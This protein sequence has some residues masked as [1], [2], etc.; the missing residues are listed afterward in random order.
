MSESTKAITPATRAM[1]KSDYNTIYRLLESGTTREAVCSAY[2]LNPHTLWLRLRK[3]RPDLAEKLKAL[4]STKRVDLNDAAA[5]ETVVKHRGRQTKDNLTEIVAHD[6]DVLAQMV[7][8]QRAAKER[9]PLKE[10][11]PVGLP[12][13]R[14]LLALAK[15]AAMIPGMGMEQGGGGTT[16]NVNTAVNHASVMRLGSEEMFAG[17]DDLTGAIIDVEVKDELQ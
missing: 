15:T 5:L 4:P 6:T 12:H 3:D 17:D 2:N 10:L 16:V 14:N 8:D 11:T 7:R 1:R 9:D 13:A